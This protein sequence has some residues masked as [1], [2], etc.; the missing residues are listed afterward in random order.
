MRKTMKD[1]SGKTAFIT[2]GASGIGLAMARSFGAVG[3]NVMLADIEEAPLAAALEDLSSRQ[4]KA[5]GVICDVSDRAA[6]QAAAAKTIE[7]F[8]KV[9]LVCNNAGVGAGGP[10]DQVKTSDWDWIVSVNLMGVVYGVEVFLP[11][12]RSHGEGGHFINTASMAGHVS[13]PGME[14]YCATKFAVVAMSE[15]WAGQ[16]APENIGVGVLCPG[17]VKTNIDT[18]GRARPDRFGGPA[19]ELPDV[20]GGLVQS[21]IDPARVG[22]RVLEA[23]LNNERYIFTHPNMRAA[24]QMR[25][26]AVMAGFDAAD[27]SPALEGMVASPLPD[28]AGGIGVDL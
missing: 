16:L 21:G 19:T 22:E 6:L 12:I 17:F 24:I 18:S 3:M 20:S 25:Y 11:L 9:H 8:G 10:I 2:G 27:A 26:A 13:P 28:L 23:V 4:I 1:L 7:T 15:G 14:P 5:D